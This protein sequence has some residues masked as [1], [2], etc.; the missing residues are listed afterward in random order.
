MSGELLDQIDLLRAEGSGTGDFGDPKLGD[1]LCCNTTPWSVWNLDEKT[2]NLS[3]ARLP[4]KWLEYCLLNIIAVSLSISLSASC[5][6]WWTVHPFC[7]ATCPAWSTPFAAALFVSAFLAYN[8]A[9]LFAQKLKVQWLADTRSPFCYCIH[10]VCFTESCKLGSVLPPVATSRRTGGVS[11]ASKKY[12]SEGGTC[13]GQMAAVALSPPIAI[14]SVSG[15]W[16][17][18]FS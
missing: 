8:H 11:L 12:S 18:T 14:T 9:S 10:I 13:P 3:L 5:D 15:V 4:L 16:F 7:S 1:M 6:D 17:S 2:R